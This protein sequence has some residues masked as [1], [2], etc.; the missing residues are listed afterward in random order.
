MKL[1]FT[2][3]KCYERTLFTPTYEDRNTA[4]EFH[5]AEEVNTSCSSCGHE[6]QKHWNDIYAI[7][8]PREI[9]K[10]IIAGVLAAIAVVVAISMLGWNVY[11]YLLSLAVGL[12]IPVFTWRRQ[13]EIAHHFNLQRLDSNVG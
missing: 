9:I 11:F 6:E 3:R 8:D 1:A 4:R 5:G 12:F 10:G 7:A 13:N 2:C